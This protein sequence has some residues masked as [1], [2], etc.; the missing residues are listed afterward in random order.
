MPTLKEFSCAVAGRTAWCWT[1]GSFRSA[2]ILV[3]PAKFAQVLTGGA[4]YALI[5]IEFPALPTF[6]PL[7]KKISIDRLTP[8]QY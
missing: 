7:R 5:Q 3:R 6:A 8:G 4:L 1:G 2:L